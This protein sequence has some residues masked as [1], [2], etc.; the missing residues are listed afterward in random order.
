M[1]ITDAASA[2]PNLYQKPAQ[3]V[4]GPTRPLAPVRPV[5]AGSPARDLPAGTIVD[6]P[7]VRYSNGQMEMRPAD[8][9]TAALMGVVQPRAFEAFKAALLNDGDWRGLLHAFERSIP[10]NPGGGWGVP[11]RG[12]RVPQEHRLSAGPAGLRPTDP[13]GH[14]WIG[15]HSSTSEPSGHRT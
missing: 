6:L 7:S 14:A 9:A 12:R 15:L 4:D 8:R 11:H 10:Q 1:S 3:F 2:P 5:L 13:A